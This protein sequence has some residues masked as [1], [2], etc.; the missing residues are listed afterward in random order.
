MLRITVEQGVDRLSSGSDL[1]ASGV[2]RKGPVS[3]GVNSRPVPDE[4]S[5]FITNRDAQVVLSGQADNRKEVRQASQFVTVLDGSSA[6]LSV[7]RAVPFTSQL[8]YYS[9]KHP[10][11]VESV[12]YQRVDTGFHVTPQLLGDV[13]EVEIAPFM[14][15]LDQDKPQQI[16]FHELSTRSRIP[17]GAWY[18]LSQQM[19]THDNLSRE[20]L[21]S[22][23]GA[24]AES[25]SIRIRI[26][27]Q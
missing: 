3:I 2:V 5:I 1:S 19:A 13:V 11:F 27:R 25:R 18:D 6:S 14:S 20:V 17:V 7:G 24:N 4:T 21:A 9:H 15:F 26:D 8:R 22:G 12:S 10:H 16:V 23:T